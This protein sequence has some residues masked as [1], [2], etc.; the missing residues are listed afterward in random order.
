MIVGFW[1]QRT[2]TGK[3]IEEIGV[4]HFSRAIWQGLWGRLTLNQLREIDAVIKDLHLHH[5]VARQHAQAWKASLA[6]DLGTRLVINPK[7]DSKSQRRIQCSLPF[8]TFWSTAGRAPLP[9]DQPRLFGLP[10]SN[11]IK[12]SARRFNS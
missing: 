8:G 7:I 12:S 2:A 3:W 11:P 4:V 5:T 10:F 1:R 9:M 6:A